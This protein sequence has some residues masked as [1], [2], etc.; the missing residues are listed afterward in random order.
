MTAK[1]PNKQ[2][3]NSSSLDKSRLLDIVARLDQAK[4]LVLGDLILDEYLLGQPERISREAPVIIFKYIES[5]F[6][7]G[8]AANAAANLASFGVETCLIGVSG[9]DAGADSLEAICKEQSIKL[10]MVRDKNRLTT[11]K[12]RI[13]SN[14]SSNP[15]NG[16]G[17]Q[18]QVLRVDRED[19]SELS[20]NDEEL[21]LEAYAKELANYDLVLLSDYSNGIFGEQLAAKAIKLAAQRKSIVDSNGDLTKFKGAYSFTPNQPDTE[22]LL[23]IKIK[24]NQELET[25]GL[26][27]K[28]LLEAKELLIT[29]GAKGMA[30]F[31]DKTLDLIPAFN[32]SEVFD[33][34]GAGDTVSA[35]YSAALAIGA[36]AL[37]A[38][39]IGNL[40]AS[41]V[42]KKFGTATTS[43]E[44]LIELIEGL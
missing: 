32:L 23:A 22:A 7:L 8:G 39:I 18:Q 33:V 19:S 41:I 34:S 35:L 38:A 4:V 28:E 24:T 26:A 10:I 30:L 44:E 25:A 6:K 12:T 29:R 3:I 17:V 15:D 9:D 37:E 11:T 20:A 43:K 16:T 1:T 42:V 5:N 40:A 13:I 21:I 14:S 36:T 2:T 31:G 27:M